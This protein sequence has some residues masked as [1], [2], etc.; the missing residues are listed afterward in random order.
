MPTSAEVTPLNISAWLALLADSRHEDAE[1]VI[2]GINHGFDIGIRDGVIKSAT[3]NCKSSAKQPLVIDNYLAAELEFRSICGPYAHP[4]LLDLQ[5]NR[6]GIIPK[7]TPGKWR[8]IT[9][10]SFPPNCSVNS[11]ISDAQA[12]VSYVGIPEAMSM[13]MNLGQNALLAKFDVSRAYR[14]LPICADQR[15]KT[16]KKNTKERIPIARSTNK[17]RIS[18][19]AI[20]IYSLW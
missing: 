19:T 15:K 18:C 5:V 20:S 9:D 2:H 11:L 17:S 13:I 8:L 10:L 4:P 6:F 3:Q 12:E 7:A 14:L 16:K 1:W